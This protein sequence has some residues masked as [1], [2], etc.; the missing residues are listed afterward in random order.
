MALVDRKRI[1]GNGRAYAG[2]QLQI[3]TYVNQLTGDLNAR[4]TKPQSDRHL[5]CRICGSVL[6]ISESLR[7]FRCLTV[8]CGANRPFRRWQS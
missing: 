3:Q 8:L 2:S 4:V 5:G 6:G 1:D 7:F